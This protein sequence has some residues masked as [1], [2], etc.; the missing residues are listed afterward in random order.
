MRN[1]TPV[2]G[3]LRPPEVP[4]ECIDQGS[5]V[6]PWSKKGS[7]APFDSFAVYPC[8]SLRAEAFPMKAGDANGL[9][10]L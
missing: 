1:Y 9:S 4:A 2:P 10:A 5:F 8:F 7:L 6:L 3:A